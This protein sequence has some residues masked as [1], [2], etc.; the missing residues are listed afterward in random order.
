MPVGINYLSQ[1]RYVLSVDFGP[2]YW[3]VDEEFLPGFSVEIGKA[4]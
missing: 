3:Y 2:Q 4:F 1:I